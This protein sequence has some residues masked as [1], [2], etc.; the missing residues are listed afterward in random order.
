VWFDEFD[1]MGRESIWYEV[2]ILFIGEGEGLLDA[3]K[4][5]VIT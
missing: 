4:S 1:I 5:L 2:N 3:A